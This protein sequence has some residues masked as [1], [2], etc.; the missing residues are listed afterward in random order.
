MADAQV[1]W[2][3]N[4]SSELPKRTARLKSKEAWLAGPRGHAAAKAHQL[5]FQGELR[6]VAETAAFATQNI[7]PQDLDLV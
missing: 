3:D 7:I 4:A 5:P 1:V 6:W 2:Q